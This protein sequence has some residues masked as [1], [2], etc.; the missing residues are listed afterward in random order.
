MLLEAEQVQTCRT[1]NARN[2]SPSATSRVGSR[3]EL[4]VDGLREVVYAHRQLTRRAGQ[5]PTAAYAFRLAELD[6]P[7]NWKEH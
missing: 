1:T 7:G 2:L 6:L 3:E 5:R 4:A